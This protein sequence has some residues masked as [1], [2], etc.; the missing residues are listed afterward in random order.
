VHFFTND[1]AWPVWQAL[2]TSQGGES[3]AY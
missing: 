2:G 1:I 3:A